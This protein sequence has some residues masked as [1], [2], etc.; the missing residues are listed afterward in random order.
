MGLRPEMDPCTPGAGSASFKILGEIPR[1]SG[2]Q[3]VWIVHGDT[4][5]DGPTGVPSPDWAKRLAKRREV[6][7]D[8]GRVKGPKWEREPRRWVSQLE[9]VEETNHKSLEIMT[10]KEMVVA[11]QQ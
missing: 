4:G 2:G 10:G 1:N 7:T 8:I 9:V 11:M 6:R 3:R 5:Q